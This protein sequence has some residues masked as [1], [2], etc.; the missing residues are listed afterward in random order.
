[1]NTWEGCANVADKDGNLLFYTN[2]RFLYNRNHV[3]M[4]GGRGLHGNPSSSQSAVVI[5]KSGIMAIV[6]E[7]VTLKVGD[8]IDVQLPQMPHSKPEPV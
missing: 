3:I 6:L 5:P 7:G 2:G 4:K 1:M 8:D